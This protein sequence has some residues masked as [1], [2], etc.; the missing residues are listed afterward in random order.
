MDISHVVNPV[1]ATDLASLPVELLDVIF[2]FIIRPSDLKAL[3]LV[4]R[5][6][7]EPAF[8]HLYR[9]VVLPYRVDDRV[10]VRVDTLSQSQ[11]LH[12]VQ[13]IDIGQSDLRRSDGFCRNLQPLLRRLPKNALKS[14]TY[15][16]HG[17]PQAEDLITVW[18]EQ[19]TLRKLQLDF[20]LCAPSLPDV[21]GYL[22]NDLASLTSIQELEVDFGEEAYRFWKEEGEEYALA[23]KLFSL[24]YVQNLSSIEVRYS[25]ID[26]PQRLGFGS[27]PPPE[28]TLVSPHFPRTLIR[29]SLSFVCLP[30]PGEWALSEYHAL[31]ALELYDCLNVAPILD[32]I[33]QPRL[34]HF[35]IRYQA[36]RDNTAVYLATRSFLKRFSTLVSLSVEMYLEADSGERL[37]PAICQHGL[38]LRSLRI[39]GYKEKPGPLDLYNHLEMCPQ[40]EFLAL[41]LNMDRMVERCEVQAESPRVCCIC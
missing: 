24:L 6:V 28:V 27:D 12:H 32:S 4:C 14:F 15:G 23:V 33:R 3:C 20:N 11:H 16:L 21:L 36:A 5:A 9:N 30:P 19:K 7:S 39:E 40:L 8:R 17:R 1:F 37:A 35:E 34:K 31:S 25:G 2:E 13:S 10:W 22:A 29:L 26:E 41:P 38:H 18:R